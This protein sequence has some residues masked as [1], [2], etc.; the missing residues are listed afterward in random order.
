MCELFL[1]ILIFKLPNLGRVGVIFTKIAFFAGLPTINVI[2]EGEL[3]R[4]GRK[5]A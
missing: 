4:F 3:P 2:T 1:Q 5:N